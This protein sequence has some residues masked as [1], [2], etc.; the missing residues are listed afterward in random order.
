MTK[1]NLNQACLS[2]QSA[3]G[4]AKF[5]LVLV[6][7]G[8]VLAGCRSKSTTPPVST[9]V[10]KKA[11]TNLLELAHELEATLNRALD[12]HAAGTDTNR[13]LK[14]LEKFRE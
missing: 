5:M 8:M 9:P 11:D 6:L 10:H 3:A 14:E 12:V 1:Q 4:S 2:G 7:A 13:L